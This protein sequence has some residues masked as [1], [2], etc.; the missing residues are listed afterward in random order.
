MIEIIN[1]N[2]VLPGLLQQKAGEI[3]HQKQSMQ[4]VEISC[5]MKNR[6]G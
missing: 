6:D 2:D 4:R 5:R 3:S 1:Q